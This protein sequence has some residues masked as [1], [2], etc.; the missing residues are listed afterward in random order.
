[1]KF[2]IAAAALCT[3]ATLANAAS[4]A[5]G[6]SGDR[7]RSCTARILYSEELPFAPQGYWLVNVTLEIMPPNGNAYAM[8][9]HEWMPWQGPPP[10]RGRTFRLLCDPA[11]PGALRLPPRL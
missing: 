1:M 8:T 11:N 10:R 5:H 6:R 3:S 9:L 2:L 4:N 7:L